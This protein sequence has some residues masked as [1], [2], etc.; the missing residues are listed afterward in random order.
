LSDYLVSDTAVSLG[1]FSP[2]DL[3]KQ[4]LR[5]EFSLHSEQ[6]KNWLFINIGN[7]DLSH[8]HTI[9]YLISS[10]AQWDSSNGQGGD[11]FWKL[12][13]MNV[14]P[15]LM[16][17]SA[18]VY[19]H[20]LEQVLERVQE[21]IAS[22]LAARV[23]LLEKPYPESVKT[24]AA[25]EDI[26]PPTLK[27]SMAWGTWKDKIRKLLADYQEDGKKLITTIGEELRQSKGRQGKKTIADINIEIT[28]AEKKREEMWQKFRKREYLDLN[29]DWN[30]AISSTSYRLLEL[31][32]C[33]PTQVQRWVTVSI[34]LLLFML[35]IIVLVGARGWAP[36]L[37]KQTDFIVSCVVVVSVCLVI[38]LLLYLRYRLILR[39]LCRKAAGVANSLLRKI[40]IDTENNVDYLIDLFNFSVAEQNLRRL[41]QKRKDLLQ[42]R[43]R[44][45]W[46]ETEVYRH[47][48]W[49]S[50]LCPVTR[51]TVDSEELSEYF[52]VDLEQESQQPC[53]LSP[54]FSLA[55][56]SSKTGIIIKIGN[57]ENYVEIAHLPGMK[58]LSFVKEPF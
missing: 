12:E 54:V 11:K 3:L 27:S 13:E 22:P 50:I 1:Q 9:S 25:H 8:Y 44:W 40:H 7:E 18:I 36:E 23:S 4:I 2:A 15:A 45:T 19:R 34:G 43:S 16:S 26:H 20:R 38:V 5:E 28:A 53:S 41:E 24:F 57:R 52:N 33:R 30:A 35:P 21:Q 51:G 56:T 29:H 10:L 32:L 48:N 58:E 55:E 17:R 46:F 31:F 49:V 14:D 42:Q 37:Y 6:F 39:R 47:L